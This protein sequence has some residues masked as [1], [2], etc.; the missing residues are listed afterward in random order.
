MEEE[1][2]LDGWLAAAW[3]SS[4]T[5]S[6]TTGTAP[7]MVAGLPCRGMGIGDRGQHGFPAT[8]RAAVRVRQRAMRT[9]R[10]TNGQTIFVQAGGVSWGGPKG[11]GA[12]GLVLMQPGAGP[13][14][15]VMGFRQ[16]CDWRSRA[17]CTTNSSACGSDRLLL[18]VDRQPALLS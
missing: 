16:D 8:G 13:R 18:G 1:H 7:T 14:T 15:H 6:T 12:S 11:L 4:T 3:T 9:R 10:E 17:S 2:D 5:S